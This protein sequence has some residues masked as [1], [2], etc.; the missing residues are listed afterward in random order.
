MEANPGTLTLPQ[1]RELSAA[2]INRVSL[3]AQSFDAGELR[4]LDRIHS[5][6]AIGAAVHLARRARI[7]QVGLDLIY[8]I[9]GQEMISWHRNL[10]AAI[11]LEPDHVSCYA[12]TIEEGTPLGLRVATGKVQPADEEL[13]AKMY[14]AA[15]DVLEAAGYRQYELS[16]WA[17]P[18][19]ESRHNMAYWQDR[20][21][22]G[23]GAGAHGYLD[24]TRYENAAHPRAYIRALLEGA[25]PPAGRAIAAS[26]RPSPEMAAS[27]W[28]I[29]RLRLLAG[30]AEGEFADRFG[31][32]LDDA[33]GPVLDEMVRAGVLC[34][35]GDRCRL[36]RRGRLLH[37]ELAA[38]LVA[39][40]DRHPLPGNAPAARAD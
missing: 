30:F 15:T 32:P 8:G 1:L 27:D 40:L 24:G 38:R 33:A 18:G 26:Y 5:P 2:G 20:D 13:V 9:P 28:I 29:L 16:N 19:C 4:F 36:T 31:L 3:G 21:Y 35:K 14:E 22:L 23:L 11:A 6:E 39:H 25:A 17:R 7:A 12:L 10:E 34:R 37:G